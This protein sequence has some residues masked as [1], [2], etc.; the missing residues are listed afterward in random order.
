M[1]YRSVV[2]TERGSPQVLQVIEN[3]L[4][5]PTSG[6]ARIK[7]LATG[8]GLTDV[9][10]R[11][12]YYPYAPKI[13]F[14]P[15]YEI[16]GVVDALGAGVTSVAVGDRV[17]A[18]T[19]HGGYAE[20]IYLGGEHLVSV[21]ASL[22]PAQAVTLVLNYTTAYQMIHRSAKVR[23]GDRV[24]ITGAS[25][26]VGTAL[27]QLG[28]LA[29][30]RMYGTASHSNHDI[31]IELGATPI[32]YTT[33]DFVR[34][35]YENEPNGLDFVFDGIGGSYIERAF[36]VLRRGGKLVE[37]GYPNFKSMLLGYAKLSL[38]GALPNGKSGEFYGIT[39]MYQK[40]KRPFLEDLPKLFNLLE[41][42]ELKPVISH[43]LPILEAAKA[44]EL[45]ESG[46]VRGKIVLLAP[47]LLSPHSPEA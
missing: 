4:R 33:Q 38:L 41:Q 20:Y 30:L 27:L 26:G 15:G 2:I 16:V 46:G 8:V 31:L 35:I 23:A 19:V 13:P 18:L 11:Y 7:I 44:N 32:D 5:E 1:Q 21:P 42:G 10:M 36:K 9:A 45:L 17:A 40:G 34:V 28:R 3:D 47:E 29:D 25:G 37:Y 24:L 43:R 6:E 39:A 12:G 14:V 22:D